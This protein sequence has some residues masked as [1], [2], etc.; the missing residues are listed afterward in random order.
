VNATE[1]WTN[2]QITTAA[3][4]PDRLIVLGGGVVGVEM[5]DAFTSFGS[6]H[7]LSSS[8]TWCSPPQ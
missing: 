2:R 3:S 4:V 5:A 6:R 8:S 1:A 7:R